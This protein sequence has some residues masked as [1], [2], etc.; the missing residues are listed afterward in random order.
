[1]VDDVSYSRV[2]ARAPGRV[3]RCNGNVRAHTQGAVPAGRA[4]CRQRAAEV[5]A[6]ETLRATGARDHGHH[7]RERAQRDGH[8]PVPGHGPHGQTR[9]VL[10]PG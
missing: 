4:G 6:Q 1:M 9:R 2:R 7:Q 5:R 8:L 3:R 10:V